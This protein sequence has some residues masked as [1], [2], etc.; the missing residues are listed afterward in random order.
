[1][2]V[3][4]HT[5][6]VDKKVDVPVYNYVTCKEDGG[7]VNTTSDSPLSLTGN[8]FGD[9]GS[10][11]AKCKASGFRC[12]DTKGCENYWSVSN[13]LPK[14]ITP[15]IEAC[16]AGCKNF[17]KCAS[18]GATNY[19]SSLPVNQLPND[20]TTTTEECKQFYKCTCG[21]K[22]D[23]Y[24]T[25]STVSDPLLFTTKDQ[26]EKDKSCVSMK[27]CVASFWSDKN[28]AMT[29][30]CAIFSGIVLLILFIIAIILKV[31]HSLDD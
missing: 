30:G 16:K 11:Q 8:T 27:P 4:T 5:V 21:I 14:D 18:T 20:V 6:Y 29:A 22:C 31:T 10:C 1:M 28:N 9:I 17:Y 23:P 15:T 24:F 13:Q 2:G 7:C 19:W 12:Y 25:N 26:C 3:V